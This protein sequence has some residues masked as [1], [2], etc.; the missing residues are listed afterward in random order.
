MPSLKR[1][2]KP[3]SPGCH[4]IAAV[5]LGGEPEVLLP[6]DHEYRHRVGLLDFE[7]HDRGIHRRE[8]RR[9]HADQLA[10]HEKLE[11]V[12]HRE[13]AGDDLA[14]G[15]DFDHRCLVDQRPRIRKVGRRDQLQQSF[16]RS[17]VIS[18]ALLNCVAAGTVITVPSVAV[19]VPT[20]AGAIVRQLVRALQHVVDGLRR[21]ALRDVTRDRPLRPRL[22]GWS[23]RCCLRLG[24]V[25][26][27]LRRGAGGRLRLGGH[28]PCGAAEQQQRSGRCGHQCA[29]FGHVRLPPKQNT[30]PRTN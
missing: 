25:C 1:P 9:V 26:L 23:F 13:H 20:S 18:F 2:M 30:M 15:V 24:S 22:L 6:V 7:A 29:S 11:V 28:L 17:V 16:C 27:G 4:W 10:V 14:V 5:E 19:M 12:V 21:E 8:R 3:A